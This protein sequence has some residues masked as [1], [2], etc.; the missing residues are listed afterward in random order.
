M[1]SD[2]RLVKSVLAAG[3]LI[4]MGASEAAIVDDIHRGHLVKSVAEWVR[5]LEKVLFPL[6]AGG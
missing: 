2:D 4:A 5:E 6:P 3:V 1:Q